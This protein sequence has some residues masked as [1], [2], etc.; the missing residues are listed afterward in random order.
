[1]EGVTRGRGEDEPHGEIF[2]NTCVSLSRAKQDLL[3][4]R[5]PSSGFQ[6]WEALGGWGHRRTFLSAALPA[7]EPWK[8]TPPRIPSPGPRSSGEPA[9]PGFEVTE[10]LPSAPQNH[11]DPPLPIWEWVLG[12]SF[13]KV[14]ALL[15][16]DSHVT[17]FTRVEA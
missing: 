6:G 3:L 1:M 16:C 17:T 14:T 12:G 2:P 7:S 9:S 10:A 13:F 15:R 8:E 5:G 11:T 4:P